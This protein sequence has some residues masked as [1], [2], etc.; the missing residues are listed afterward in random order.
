MPPALQAELALPVTSIQDGAAPPSADHQ[1]AIAEAQRAAETMVRAV[2]TSDILIGM[3][4]VGG[5][6][7]RLLGERG[8]HGTTIEV[9]APRVRPDHGMDRAAV[10]DASREIAARLGAEQTTSLHLLLALLR[11]GGS[12]TEVLRLTGVEPAKLRGIVMR[13]LTGHDAPL[14]RRFPR[15]L[16]AASVDAGAPVRPPASAEASSDTPCTTS[17]AG[18]G[19]PAPDAASGNECRLAPLEP[20]RVPVLHREREL[21]RLLDLLQARTAR[22]IAIVGEPGSGRS[23]LLSALAA[24]SL[25]PPLFPAGDLGTPGSAGA[26]LQAFHRCAPV[27]VPI[28]LDGAAWL[29]PEGG[30]GILQLLSLVN[31]GR[32]FLLSLTP[33]DVRRLET[34]APDLTSALETVLLVPP[35]PA[36]LLEMAEAGLDALAAG[37][38]LGFS[39]DVGPA[40]LRLSPRYPSERAQ[41]GRALAIAEV[42]LARAKRLGQTEISAQDIAAVVGDAS[43]VPANQLLRD[44]DERF[45]LLEDRLAERV[46]G[47]AE[48]RS[49]IAAVLRRSYAGFRGHKPLAS[50]LL[51]GPTGVGKTETARAIAEA[52]FD[53]E[54]ALVR[55]DLSEYSEPHAVA[56]LIGSPPGYLAHEDGGQLTEAIRRRPAAVVLFDEL[57]KAHR[58]VL[59]VLLQV[60]EDGRLTDGRGRTVDFSSAAVVMTSNLGS[61][62]YRRA[63]TPSPNTITALARSRLPPELWNRIDEVLCYAPLSEA[64]LA[65]IVARIARDSNQHLQAERGIGF[66]IDDSVVAQVLRVETDRSLGARPLRRA[67]ERLVEGP[68]ASEIV[69]GRLHRGARLHIGCDRSGALVIAGLPTR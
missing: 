26:L 32:R 68:L 6:A 60:L 16:A 15:P 39:A 58:E 41:P 53:G 31:A 35:E 59:L 9:L 52:L 34:V 20:P 8:I 33:A 51:L 54:S 66:E 69:A 62:C 1:M 37:A 29:G 42:A 43:G 3:L 65:A 17:S 36:T 10:A 13:A 50:F 23:A 22:A 38:N 64:E 57:E 5:A 18:G 61:E 28:V 46:V 4:R 14:E 12:A 19:D 21:G 49:R 48:A 30:D 11:A 44:D 27:D 25:E 67:F 56:R 45:R 63:R 40:L 47:H 7:A 2:S 24:A 55:I